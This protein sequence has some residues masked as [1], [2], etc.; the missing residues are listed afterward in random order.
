MLRRL[1]RV[2]YLTLVST[3]IGA[4]VMQPIKD[5]ALR[6]AAISYDEFAECQLG[7]GQ[8][9]VESKELKITGLTGLI[10]GVLATALGESPVVVSQNTG[11][12]SGSEIEKHEQDQGA[13]EKETVDGC[14]TL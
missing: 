1:L 6:D 2:F 8:L 11:I 10:G 12:T 5:Q 13:V 9:E 3:L 4:C 14:G 7:S